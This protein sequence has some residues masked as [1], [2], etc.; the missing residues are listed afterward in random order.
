MFKKKAAR[1][2]HS[3]EPAKSAPRDYRQWIIFLIV[4]VNLLGYG[5]ILPLLPYFAEHLGASPIMIGLILAAYSLCQLIATPILGELSDKFGRRPI[6]LFSLAGT[7]ISFVMLGLGNTIFLVFVARII[8]GLSGG[9]ISTAQ[10]YMADITKKEDRTSGMG[11]LTA[12]FSLGLILGPALGGVLSIYGYGVPAIV[13]A[14]VTLVSLVITYFWLPETIHRS[15][16]TKKKKISTKIIDVQDFV[17]ALRHPLVGSVMMIYFLIMFAYSCL[18]GVFALF[19]EHVFHYGALA[20]GYFFAYLGVISVVIQIFL[21]KRMMKLTSEENWVFLG[22]IGVV[23]GMLLMGLAFHFTLLAI[24]LSLFAVGSSIGSPVLTALVSKFSDKDTQG[25]TLGTF[26]S[27]GSL[28]RLFGPLVATFF[29]A[30]LGERSPFMLAA[31]VAFLAALVS[32]YSFHQK[33]RAVA[34]S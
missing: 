34:R 16:E 21:L 25:S 32:L 18:Q 17:R 11:L 7:V 23:I 10:A 6:L 26:Q 24:G 13:A 15:A 27:L 5:I 1:P 9:N 30:N 4:F 12:A 3:S 31:F 19:A 28:G 22:S 29:Y 8:D 20:S 14:V 33:R 2:S